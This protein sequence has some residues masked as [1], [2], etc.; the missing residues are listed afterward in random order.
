MTDS[1]DYTDRVRAFAQLNPDLYVPDTGDEV[2]FQ[3]V[4][5]TLEEDQALGERVTYDLTLGEN[6]RD[7]LRGPS[8]G[9]PSDRER[10]ATS[11]TA[12]ITSRAENAQ[13]LVRNHAAQREHDR[14]DTFARLT[15]DF[16]VLPDSR[17][18]TQH[19]FAQQRERALALGQR[20]AA[21]EQAEKAEREWEE[22]SA[23]FQ[24]RRA[25]VERQGA[26][27]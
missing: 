17:D 12:A 6:I 8:D 2:V 24:V 11:R 16:G 4:A 22:P 14:Q 1:I 18:P 20:V 10:Y 9:G 21:A 15:P 25:Q 26:E 13:R 7:V 3:A 23:F 5:R 27:R 19:Q